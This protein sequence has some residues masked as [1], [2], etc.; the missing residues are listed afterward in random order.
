M[1]HWPGNLRSMTCGPIDAEARLPKTD[2]TLGRVMDTRN[3]PSFS[4][5]INTVQPSNNAP[6]HHHRKPQQQEA[7]PLPPPLAQASAGESE[8]SA[9]AYQRAHP[10]PFK[11]RGMHVEDVQTGR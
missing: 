6:A 5:T 1:V 10:G 3:G 8:A 7:A 9:M 2:L 11:P 4:P